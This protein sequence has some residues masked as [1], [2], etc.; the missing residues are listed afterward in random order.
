MYYTDNVNTTVRFVGSFQYQLQ[1][2]SK[3]WGRH[4]VKAERL[5]GLELTPDKV[6]QITP[7]TWLLDWWANFGGILQWFSDAAN[8]HMV[9][10][11]G[12]LIVDSMA[13]RS[14]VV[15][16]PLIDGSS[17]TSAVSGRS[18]RYQRVRA[19]PYGFGIDSNALSNT[20]WAILGALGMTR[21]P[22]VL[23]LND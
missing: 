8:D 1:N 19:N 9:L 20:Q 21:A 4:L 23:R 10:R 18:T 22:K 6:W 7:W 3:S 14:C 12:Y 15:R 5:L 11:Y 13:T 17:F 16:I 2:L